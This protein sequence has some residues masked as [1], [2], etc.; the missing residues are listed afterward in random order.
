[1]LPN[2]AGEASTKKQIFLYSI[3]LAVSGVAPWYLGFAGAAY[4]VASAIL[5]A[6]FVWDAWKVLAMPDGDKA[7]VPAKKLFGFS[8]LYL[9]A[10][11]GVLLIEALVLH[12]LVPGV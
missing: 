3:L 5:G 1:M 6:K 9:F 4:G 12:F 10:I 7:M 11:F 8:L 2:V